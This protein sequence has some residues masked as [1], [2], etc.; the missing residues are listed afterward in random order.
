MTFP[1]PPTSPQEPSPLRKRRTLP[2]TIAEEGAETQV[3][4]TAPPRTLPRRASSQRTTSSSSLSHRASFHKG[5]SLFLPPRAE[6]PTTDQEEPGLWYSAPLLFAI[7]PAVG[8]VAFK[9]GSVLLTDLVLLVLAAVYLNWCLISPW[10]WYHQARSVRVEADP[11]EE[12]DNEEAV[13]EEEENEAGDEGA[14]NAGGLPNE[15]GKGIDQSDAEI[16]K[17]DDGHDRGARRGEASAELHLHE[18]AA[19]AMCIAGPLLGSYVLHMIRHSLSKLHGGQL[20]SNL[21]L[22]LFVLGAELRPVRHCMKLVQARTLHLQRVVRIDPHTD[23]RDTADTASLQELAGRVAEM[24]VSIAE[25]AHAQAPK[26]HEPKTDPSATA[27][28]VKRMQQ[29]LQTQIDALNRAVR[30]YEKRA[31]AQVM[32]TEARLQDLE[33]RSKDA[34]SL[35][36]AAASYSQKPGAVGMVI[37]WVMQLIKSVMNIITYPLRLVSRL[38]WSVIQKLGLARPLRRKKGVDRQRRHEI[39]RV[40]K[41]RSST[42]RTA[43]SP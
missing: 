42:T 28:D 32:Q 9:K 13:A 1:K 11:L 23:S 19:L 24:E 17:N 27:D 43:R 33:T 22:T 26:N 8:G 29:V 30:R 20:V 40:G 10:I 39:S 3:K 2:A 25:N 21:H 7:V 12:F 5:D 34:I 18:L 35:A 31:T 37:E 41:D 38:G 6:S 36:A 14:P 4:D 15:H 16:R